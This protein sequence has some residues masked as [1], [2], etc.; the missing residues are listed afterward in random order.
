[1]DDYL[2]FLKAKAAQVPLMTRVLEDYCNL[3]GLKVNLEKSKAMSSKKCPTKE[4]FKIY[5]NF[6][7]SVF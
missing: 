4:G 1:M 7:H 5:C 6:L 2:L 3:L